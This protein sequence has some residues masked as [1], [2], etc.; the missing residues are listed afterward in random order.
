M[1][2]D[3]DGTLD[4]RR[5]PCASKLFHETTPELIREFLTFQCTK[6]VITR[7]RSA[8]TKETGPPR[9]AF[10][11]P[12]GSDKGAGFLLSPGDYKRFDLQAIQM[13]VI[14]PRWIIGG[15]FAA[16]LH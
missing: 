11:R 5:L 8:H 10:G 9:G 3:D 1:P 14:C 13:N 12:A 7:A 15:K 2:I 4:D 6:K 16:K